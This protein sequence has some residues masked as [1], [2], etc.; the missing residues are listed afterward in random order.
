ME[1]GAPPLCKRRWLSC[2]GPSL[3]AGTPTPYVDARLS[4]DKIKC[5]TEQ[6]V[7][8]NQKQRNHNTFSLAKR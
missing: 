2:L 6:R 7:T 1:L 5:I 4:L 8:Q 3:L